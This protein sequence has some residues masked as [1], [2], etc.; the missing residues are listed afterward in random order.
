M[1]Q[2]SSKLTK[3]NISG[4]YDMYGDIGDKMERNKSI[5]AG[6]NFLPRIHHRTN[7]ETRMDQRMSKHHSMTGG[8]YSSTID[9]GNPYQEKPATFFTKNQSVNPNAQLAVLKESRR[10]S[11]L[12][13]KQ[14]EGHHSSKYQEMK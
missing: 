7:S 8:K 3:T 4:N 5:D 13:N 10:R 11:I 14:Q 2:L 6:K 9:E 12:L 1:T